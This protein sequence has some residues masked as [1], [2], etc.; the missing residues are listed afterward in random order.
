MKKIVLLFFSLLFLN[1]A[2]TAAT[3]TDNFCGKTII[4]NKENVFYCPQ[5]PGYKA[6]L[7]LFSYNSPSYVCSYMQDGKVVRTCTY[8]LKNSYLVLNAA[9]KIFNPA[10]QN[11]QLTFAVKQFVKNMKYMDFF[12]KDEL[13]KMDFDTFLDNL[14]KVQK[15]QFS[16]N[17][18]VA[19]EDFEMIKK[20]LIES[21]FKPGA[22]KSDK[23][24][25]SHFLI[26]LITLDPEVIKGY[27]P[28]TGQIEIN[29]E[30][31]KNTTN[32]YLSQSFGQKFSQV[33]GAIGQ[34]LHTLNPFANHTKVTTDNIQ[35]VN[36]NLSLHLSSWN[37]IFDLKLWGFYYDFMS[38]M[39][40]AVRY[41]VLLIFALLGGYVF[42][43][44]LFIKGVDTYLN[45]DEVSYKNP[46]FILGAG[47]VI[48]SVSIFFLS[49]ITKNNNGE[50]VFYKNDTVAKTF[51]RKALATGDKIATITNDFATAAYLTYALHKENMGNPIDVY[52]QSLQ[53]L[54]NLYILWRTEPMMKA[55]L[56]YYNYAGS[57]E[58]FLTLSAQSLQM[59]DPNIYK[60]SPYYKL[61]GADEIDYKSCLNLAKNFVIEKNL[62]M[63]DMLALNTT[64][65]NYEKNIPIVMKYYTLSQ[66]MVNKRYG[67]IAMVS[68]P[69]NYFIASNAELFID[70]GITQEMVNKIAENDVKSL[71]F[72]SPYET[73]GV[74]SDTKLA[75]A[76]GIGKGL[77][78]MVN[79][80]TKFILPFYAEY[81]KA[82]Y[83]ILSG[84]FQNSDNNNKEKETIIKKL[85]I[86]VGELLKKVF[87][88]TKIL[89]F[90]GGKTKYLLI[91]VA[92]YFI[93]FWLWK[94]S[95]QIILIV[96]FTL[97]VLLEIVFYFKD[98][99]LYFVL[100]VFVPIW[101]VQKNS[102]Q[103]I[104]KYLAEGVMLMF[105]PF[106]LVFVVYLAILIMGLFMALY[107]FI[108][109]L[110]FN[111]N[112]TLV[113]YLIVASNN[114]LKGLGAGINGILYVD[115][116][117]SVGEI[118]GILFQ[119]VVGF[120]VIIKGTDYI[121]KKFGY[122]EQTLFSQAV[123]KTE[124]Y[125]NPI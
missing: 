9:D 105:K 16:S 122:E 25:F 72:K 36:G 74:L 102:R 107:Y 69:M 40:K 93:S 18:G 75:T 97:M 84:M 19:Q 66:I 24:T 54:R 52:S 111:I 45:R 41:A 35:L 59:S 42:G 57:I 123:T 50:E 14:K 103:R 96:G 31:Y 110:T 114:G 49:P 43:K 51:I 108:L 90:L 34:V 89:A 92:A 61:T 65:Q 10:I 73:G 60:N 1:A 13:D 15:N 106:I 121:L 11:Y 62:I 64:L 23:Y 117:K 32:F 99:L 55:C 46:D 37:K 7:S 70:N 56:A 115:S 88:V 83:K 87:L 17:A 68:S 4:E 63:T 20:Y 94:L 29:P 116:I 67:W 112:E 30:W 12:T 78:Y 5:K 2:T 125:V 101:S 109:G 22:E 8:T 28:A 21:H 124:K 6:I 71:N 47:A 48:M 104:E 27:N 39:D 82:T 58:K 120:L 79:I 81:Y 85:V 113:Q 76:T 100:S 26:S 44:M 33:I 53:D 38:K 118:L 98:V 86:K 91:A 77:G 80:G 95:F 119:Y 3:K